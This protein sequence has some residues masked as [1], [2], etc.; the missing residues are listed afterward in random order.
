MYFGISSSRHY[1]NLLLLSM[2]RRR[3]EESHFHVSKA[4]GMWRKMPVGQLQV[5]MREMLLGEHVALSV[6][7]CVFVSERP[8]EQQV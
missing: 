6:C 1:R 5:D 7:V 2:A 3:L 4:H 8:R